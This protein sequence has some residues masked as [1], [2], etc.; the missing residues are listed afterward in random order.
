MLFSETNRTELRPKEHAERDYDYLNISARPE[1][2]RVRRCLD[3]WFSRYPEEEQG[4]FRARFQ[5]GNDLSFLSC[6][7]ELYFHEMLLNLGYSLEVHPINPSGRSTRPDFRVSDQEGSEFYLETVLAT[8]MTDQERAANARMNVVYDALNRLG[9]PNFYLEMNIRGYPETSPSSSRLR[10]TLSRWLSQLDPDQQIENGERRPE[11]R[12]QNDGWNIVFTAIPKSPSRRGQPGI[13]PIGTMFFGFRW[14]STWQAIRDA[15]MSKG[16]H[17]G[18][19][20]APLI[21]AVNVGSFSID[22][23]DE[24]QALFGEERWIL[25]DD[26][27]EQHERVPNGLWNGPNGTRYRRVSAVI[28]AADVKPWTM[29][30]RPV[31]L[32][33]N[34]WANH[35]ISGEICRL[36]K[37]VPV[38]DKMDMRDGLH[39][40]QILNL[41]EGW[42]EVD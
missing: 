36:P 26:E 33:H 21:I 34:P 37:A 14:E 40:R 38:D 24:M 23:I 13:R 17:Y 39:P 12:Y 20:R 8:E 11:Y 19:M 31:R 1:A 3:Y 18:N 29:A 9:S 27:M 15:V 30:V 25:R 16:Q 7:F 41:S 5:F 22:P 10:T 32:F 2:Y 4:E 6:S 28:I 35:P 42:P